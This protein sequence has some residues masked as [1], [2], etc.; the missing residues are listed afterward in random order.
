MTD[1][2]REFDAIVVGAGIGGI[3]ALHK[4][5]N[6]LGLNVRAFDRSGGIGGTW[7]WNRY[8]GAKSDSEGIVYRY[9]FDKETLAEPIGEHRY[10]RQADMLAYLESVVDKFDLRRDIQL[11]TSVDAIVFDESRGVWTVTTGDGEEYT[12]TRVVT[13]LGPLSTTHF[14]EFKGRDTFRGRMVHTATW[15]ADLNIEG[16]RV[17]VIGTGSTGTQFICAASKIVDHLTV[18]QRTAQY[19][20]PNGDAPLTEEFKAEYRA[21]HEKIWDE[22]WTSYVGC[23]FKESQIGAMSVSEEE[24]QRIFQAAW[25]K[26]NAFRFMVETFNDIALDEKANEAAAEFIRSKVREIVKDPETARKLMPWGYYAR[27]PISNEDYYETFNRDNV[28]LVS[29]KETPIKEITPNGVLTEDGVEHELDV[30]VFATGFD[31][32]D[33]TYRRMDIRGRGGE[34]IQEHWKDGGSSYLGIACNGF[35]NMFMVFGPRTV[36]SNLPPGIETQVEWF[37]EL[38][39]TGLERGKPYIEAT[40]RAEKEWTAHCDEAANMSLFS[41]VDSFINGANIPGKKKGLMFYVAGL[42]AYR[43]KLAEV[44]AADYDGFVFQEDPMPAESRTVS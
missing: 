30:L 6:E 10:I 36:Y 40:A 9:S 2:V 1:E 34:T 12:A 39:K 7:Y 21:N 22:V 15:P 25:D 23:G 13:A 42:A 20:V 4:L 5:R 26:G 3:Y 35:P 17:G 28:S 27:R 8:P 31:A 11:N 37:T 14:P 38:I 33:G 32:F 16:K 44:V 18:F 29:L 19:V 24:R 43:H 41:K